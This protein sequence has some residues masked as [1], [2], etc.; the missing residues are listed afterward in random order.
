MKEA[1]AA[2]KSAIVAECFKWC[3]PHT[4]VVVKGGYKKVMDKF[5]GVTRA[6]IRKYFG[7]FK[8]QRSAGVLSPDMSVKRVGKCGRPTKLTEVLKEHYRAIGQEYATLWIKLTVRELQIELERLGFHLSVSTIHGHLKQL[9]AKEIN[10]RIKP[11]L[12]ETHKRNRMTFI[13]NKANRN[14]GLNRPEHYWKDQLDTIHVD[15][16]W[17]FMQ[18]INN[19]VLVWDG[20]IIP[21]A[22]TT[23]H[24]SH[25]TKV[26]FLVALARPQR[27]PD[28][29]WF[30]GRIGMWPCVERRQA[31]RNSVNRPAGTWET[32]PRNID[33]EYYIDLMIG[34]GGVV[35]KIKEKLHWKQDIPLFIQQDGA[36][37]HT[38]GGNFEL[39]AQ[40]GHQGGW[41]IS[42]VTQPAQSP[43]LNILD[44]SF[45]H[46][47]KSRASKVKN[48]ARNIDELITNITAEYDVYDRHT[49]DHMWAHLY[50]CWNCILKDNGGNQY[51]AP[52]SGSRIRHKNADTSV[53]LTIDVDEYNR[54]SE[55]MHALQL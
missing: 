54:V 7:D 48:R 8:K 6:A 41:N 33:G 46:A 2:T 43:D 17:F 32:H 50:A 12:T 40:A 47:L 9:K 38:K 15:E 4:D 34:P 42:L 20:I 53:D 21:D 45:F 5:P 29:T 3:D 55:L 24:K 36:S 14:H 26:M 30:D 44:L 52:H 11:L 28:G 27:R 13:L 16:S 37:P 18:N 1:D 25:I 49:L 22:P 23:R 19:H 31:V 10:I 51:K 35:D 39:I